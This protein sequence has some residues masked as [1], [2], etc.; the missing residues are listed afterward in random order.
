[1]NGATVA[2]LRLENRRWCYEH[3]GPVGARA[4]MLRILRYIGGCALPLC[5]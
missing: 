1:L 3:I 4:E 2:C 5:R